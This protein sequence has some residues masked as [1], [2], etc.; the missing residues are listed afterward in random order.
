MIMLSGMA[1]QMLPF[2][3]V[4]TMQPSPGETL[5]ARRDPDA[6]LQE[7]ATT[8]QEAK[9]TDRPSEPDG[10]R[11][12]IWRRAAARLGHDFTVLRERVWWMLTL[13]DCVFS[14]ALSNLG[15]LLPLLATDRAF[16][17]G[18]GALLLT[19]SGCAE[20]VSRLAASA[21]TGVVTHPG[22]FLREGTNA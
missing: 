2:A 3:L 15:M 20:L 4:Q 9:Q 8:D 16:P 17:P 22:E 5:P 13:T 10:A 12:T 18:T 19:V 14:L 7:E 1:I 11:S 21:L 6:D